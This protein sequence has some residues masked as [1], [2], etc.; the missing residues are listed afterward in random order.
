MKILILYQ[1]LAFYTIKCIEAI[2]TEHDAEVHV[3]SK[4]VNKEAPFQFEEKQKAVH[5]YRRES[6][7]SAELSQL[8]ERIQPNLIFCAG[9]IDKL[10]LN[11]VKKYHRRFPTLLGM[12]NPWRATFRQYLAIVY[13]RIILKP[14]FEFAFVPGKRQAFFAKKIGFTDKNILTGAY[15]ADVDTFNSYYH[16]DK[17]PNHTFLY[18]GRYVPQKNIEMLWQAFVEILPEIGNQWRLICAGTG[19]IPPFVHPN[20]IHKGFVQPQDFREILREADVYILPSM[21]E[22][23]GVSVHE[24]AAAGFPMILSTE[25]GAGEEF[26][27]EAK[28]GFLFHPSQ[29]EQ[30][31]QA[32][33]RMTKLSD[34]ELKKM[35]RHSHALAQRITPSTWAATLMRAIQSEK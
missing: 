4:Q 12:D 30:L 22:P 17:K 7:S 10:Y 16:P 23:W 27:Q 8:V 18:I 3:I 25:V 13:G 28:N 14:Y 31:Q 32:M 19:C 35:G 5:F 1:E 26:L 29:K 15:S 24:M 33:L 34:D 20:I 6:I 21:F 9:W 11:L 2:V